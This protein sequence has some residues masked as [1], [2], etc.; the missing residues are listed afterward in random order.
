[1]SKFA[2][3][4]TSFSIGFSLIIVLTA[5]HDDRQFWD[6]G[7]RED[8]ERLEQLQQEHQTERLIGSAPCKSFRTLL[9][10]CEKGTKKQIEKAQ[11]EKRQH[12]QACIKAYKRQ[13]S[14]VDISCTNAQCISDG[15]IHLVQGPMCRRRR[16]R[17]T[18]DLNRGS[19][20]DKRDGHRAARGTLEKIVEC[21]LIG[22]NVTVAVAMYSPRVVKEVLK[23]LGKQLVDDGQLDSVSLYAA[24]PTA[25]FLQLDAQEWQDDEYS[26]IS[27]EICS[28]QSRS[29]EE[30][31]RTSIGC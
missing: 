21:G 10:P 26:T 27:K 5:Q 25:D 15:R 17:Q 28:T 30:K 13:L 22:Q 4:F 31:E 7:T 8:Q 9:H 6:L 23:A 29:R 16:M 18:I 11:D 24:G 12:T 14:M 20:V 3:K 2:N 19:C 1:M